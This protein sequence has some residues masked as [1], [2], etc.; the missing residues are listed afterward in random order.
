M[1]CNS[2]ISAKASIMVTQI[3]D[4]GSESA[5]QIFRATPLHPPTSPIHHYLERLQQFYYF[6][7]IP[8]LSFTSFFFWTS[9]VLEFTYHRKQTCPSKCV[10]KTFDIKREE[11]KS[12]S[13]PLVHH[14]SHNIF[15]ITGGSEPVVYICHTIIRSTGFLLAAMCAAT[16]TTQASCMHLFEGPTSPARGTSSHLLHAR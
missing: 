16:T 2:I 3:P 5:S 14:T 10:D 6:I 8:L 1:K 9:I 15:T 11:K 12:L 7:F 4:F 13:R